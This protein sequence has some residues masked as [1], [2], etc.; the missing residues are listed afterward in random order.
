MKNFI[1]S[2]GILMSLISLINPL[3]NNGFQNETAIRQYLEKKKKLSISCTP[4]RNDLSLFPEDDFSMIP[5]PGWGN[6]DW[7]IKSS[8]DS[9]KFYFRQGINMYYSFHIIESLASFKKASF[10]DPAAPMPYWGIALA[11]GP[12]IND[13]T[14]YATP[15]ALE[16][17]KKA[18]TL[19]K[20]TSDFE[21]GLINAMLLRYS[22]DSSK[23]RNEL[24]GA[25]ARAMKEL[26][27]NNPGNPDAG[28]LYADAL[29]LLHPWDLY[30]QQQ[31]PK[32]W[33]PELVDVLEKILQQSPNHPAANHYYIH[34]VEASEN[35]GRAI[36]SADKLGSLLPN[37]SHMV[38]MPSHIYIRTGMYQK[39][40][41][42]NKKAI[43]GYNLYN[44]L[45]P[46]VE[47]GAFLYLFHNIHMQATCA[48]LNGD[49]S[50]AE[51][52][53]IKLKSAIPYEYLSMAPPDA[54][55]LQYMYSTELFSYVRYG[56]WQKILALPTVPDSL[57]YA[58]ILLEFGKGISFARLG[59]H[60]DAELSLQKM[61]QLLKENDRLK[62]R[63]GAFNTAYAGGEIAI[64]ML[65][66][67]IAEE[68]NN[69]DEAIGLLS[70]AVK[71][72][73]GLIY[74]EPRDWLLPVRQY[75]AAVH[76]KKGDFD[77]AESILRKDLKINPD[78]G[79][80]L[81]GLW[82][83]LN[84]KGN[85]KGAASIKNALDGLGNQKDFNKNSPVF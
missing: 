23:K 16:A 19:L 63:M 81:S 54:E 24:D 41:E 46:K 51:S 9:A 60:V 12:N 65:K 34:A 1:L 22:T 50:E 69:L 26:Y 58:K 28:A 44:A 43:D 15:F 67:I 75:L 6:Y 38:H 61:N 70:V 18:E 7:K 3:I 10:L 36:P 45:Y 53:A 13:V 35:P 4:D 37:V 17:I 11:Y 66:G 33:T 64:T 5:L 31:K 71:L 83:T 29:M 48:I 72:E 47:N 68:K 49:F 20:G 62:I 73:D 76:I 80:A 55:Y 74:N 52:L 21:K 25:Y 40:N 85:K 8:S 78:N 32:T 82:I 57:A 39:G 84:I 27:I 56:K 2:F 79:W 42:V 14:Y 30:D 77:E 59:R